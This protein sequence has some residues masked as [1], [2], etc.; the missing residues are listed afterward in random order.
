[1]A[2][3]VAYLHGR[4]PPIVHKDIKSANYLVIED[5]DTG[6]L[7]IRLSDL[8]SAIELMVTLVLFAGPPFAGAPLEGSLL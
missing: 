6:A 2:Q 3:A 8:G 1:M 5:P 7:Q 4:T